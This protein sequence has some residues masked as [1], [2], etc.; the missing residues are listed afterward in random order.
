MD[1]DCVLLGDCLEVVKN[2]DS[3]SIDVIY[4]DPP[5]FTNKIQKQTTKDRA[6]ILSFDDNWSNSCEYANF[7]F[8][9]FKEFY[10]ILKDTGSIFVHCDIHANHIV[11]C[12]LDSVFGVKNFRSEIIWIYKRWSNAKKGLLRNHQNIY[13]YSKTKKFT[14]NFIYENYS[15]TTNIDQIL[16]QRQRDLFGK[17]I[18]AKDSN[19]NIIP[20]K[21]K[22]GVPLS[23]V[24]DIP[25]LNPK[26]KERIHYPTQKPIAL[27]ERIIDIASNEGDVILDPFCGSGTTLLACRILGRQGFG[28]D[29]NFI[30]HLITQAKILDLD[31]KDLEYL[32]GFMDFLETKQTHKLHSYE[33]IHHWFKQEAIS[34]YRI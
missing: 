17:S 12:M 9:R 19:N 2:I 10:R 16:Q 13:F 15:P 28:F 11:R 18:Y 26:A 8:L 24:W 27:L 31:S 34:P 20:A 4:L 6:K 23:D 1:K 7:L 22:K 5:F 33:N 14:F 3:S 32:K 29:I 21:V 30:A 25:Y